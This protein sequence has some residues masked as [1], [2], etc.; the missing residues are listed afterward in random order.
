LVASG[1]TAVAQLSE[2]E[3][4]ARLLQ[5]DPTPVVR[6]KTLILIALLREAGDVAV[7]RGRLEEGRTYYL[8]GLHLLLESLRQQDA[9]DR[10][11]FVPRVDV[12]VSALANAPLPVATLARLM[13][14][15]EST[16]QLGKAE[17]TLYALLEADPANP[18]IPEFGLAFY[19]RLNH[20]PDAT[21]RAG[22]LPRPEVEAGRQEL[23]RQVKTRQETTT[24]PCSEAG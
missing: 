20:L 17:D 24:E 18:A 6:T 5:G 9:V 19:E 16:G 13:Q 3:L 8:N 12:F 1:T 2:T 15:Y 21:L 23:S 4:L 14:H 10:P 22:N 7:A 11:E